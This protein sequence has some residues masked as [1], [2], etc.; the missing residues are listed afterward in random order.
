MIWF[1]GKA[2][3]HAPGAA[4]GQSLQQR[5]A[6]TERLQQRAACPRRQRPTLLLA[7]CGPQR[8]VRA[9]AQLE[10]MYPPILL[11]SQRCPANAN[12]NTTLT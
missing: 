2:A 8:A 9:A 3:W 5:R 6:P 10:H 11:N 4:M 12:P 7:R 1:V